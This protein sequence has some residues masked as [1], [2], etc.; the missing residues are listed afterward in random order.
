MYHRYHLQTET[1]PE[2][3]PFPNRTRVKVSKRGLA[4]HLLRELFRHW[5]YPEVIV[6]RPCMYGV[7]SRPVGGF[8]PRDSVC[9]GCLRC[10]TEYPEMVQVYLNPRHRQLGDSFLTPDLVDTICYEARTGRIPVRG[11]GYRGLFGGD[12]WN[13]MWTDMSEIVRPTRDGIHGREY[14]STAVDLGQKPPFLTFT[15]QGEPVAAAAPVLTIPVP[16]L[17]DTPPESVFSDRLARILAA[18]ARATETMVILPLRVLQRLK[19]ESPHTIPL[20]GKDDRE[21]LGGLHIPPPI[22][23]LDGWDEALFQEVRRR[24]PETIV[25]LRHEYPPR[26][27][28]SQWFRSGVR[29]FH[30]LADNHGRG[31]GGRFVL[32]LIREA[33]QFFV[34]EKCR[35]EVTLLG[36]GGI[37]AGE[38]VPKA[39][40][41]GLDAVAL[42]TPVLAALQ[43]RF[44]GECAGRETSRFQLPRNITAGWG[45]RRLT[46]LVA[47]WRDQLLEVMG[48]MGLR[49][50]RR[51]RGEMGR[52][53]FQKELEREAFSGI[54]GYGG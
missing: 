23:E 35:D 40:I 45:A 7:F 38:H 28:L 17:F 50:V 43:A 34:D 25:C 31:R 53:M 11:A 21:A 32:D 19:L 48:A 54:E 30:L 47:S 12:G 9:V 26:E 22:I 1:A 36:S 33:H 27:E 42:D 15:E 24:Y 39:I 41:C 44:L 4:F 18:A 29:V 51:L 3:A 5:R 20:V 10:T 8:A 46:N 49:E 37:V 52:A 2:I 16:F 13:G 14:I 6:S